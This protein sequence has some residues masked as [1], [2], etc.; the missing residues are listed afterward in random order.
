MRDYV[1]CPRITDAALQK[2]NA[3]HPDGLRTALAALHGDPAW[4]G[5][6]PGLVSRLRG[7]GSELDCSGFGMR[8]ASA[9]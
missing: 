3:L 6:C 8:L 5:L 9:L 7:G 2:A 1:C 4:A